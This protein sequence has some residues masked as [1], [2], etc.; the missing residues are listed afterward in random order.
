M[1]K[2][3]LGVHCPIRNQCQRYT[4]PNAEGVIQ[5]CRN[6]RLFVQDREKINGDSLRR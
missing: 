5:K 1:N 3:C 4:F 2:G 6:Q